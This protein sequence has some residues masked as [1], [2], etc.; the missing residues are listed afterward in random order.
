MI[1]ESQSAASATDRQL[2]HYV[3]PCHMQEGV[4]VLF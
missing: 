2:P 4:W 3:G 1:L